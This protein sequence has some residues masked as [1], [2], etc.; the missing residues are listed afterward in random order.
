MPN[1]TIGYAA[2]DP[3]SPLKSFAFDRR[4]LRPDD[5]QIAIRYCG[6][7]HSD[8]HQA[9]NDWRGTV[10]P[11][12]PGHE[13]VGHVSAVGPKV[14]KFAVGDTV[15]VG[16]I[17]DSCLDCPSCHSGE[18]QYCYRGMTGTYGGKDRQTGEPTQGG[19]S[20]KIIVREEFVL[21][22]PKA[23]DLE[24]AAPLLCAGIT[25]YSPLR[26]WKVGP[27]QK[28]AIVGL[29]GLGHMGVKLAKG[30][31]AEVTVITTS[32]SK[33]E[34]ALKL[35]AKDVLLSTDPKAMQGANRRFDFILDT[36]PVQHD[37]GPYMRLLRTDGSL[38]LVGMIDMIPS[39]HS[40]LVL[41]GRK[42][43]SGSGIGGIRE[44]QELLDLCA[45]RNI[46]PDCET[47][48]IQDI[49]QAYERMLKNDV[50]YRF[51]IDMKTLEKE[52]AAA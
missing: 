21:S 29:G 41:G 27:G 51:V 32:Q 35:G 18:E 50:K 39:F 2:V 7:C 17:V 47:I 4:E 20:D 14:T 26:A 31:G 8:L 15:A 43:V 10:Y 48:A 6:V 52:R 42:R 28:V 30:L 24:R 25:T 37:L 22:V 33:S 16:C 12:V 13:I 3:K 19:Y 49:N 40:G 11:L 23:L 9:R 1:N 5:V 36:V 46:L 38:V 45:E 44:T 34:D